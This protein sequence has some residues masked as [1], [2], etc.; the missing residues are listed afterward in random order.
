[1]TTFEEYV[2][3]YGLHFNRKLYEWAVSMMK[4]RSGNKVQV[5]TK[6]DVN[7]FLRNNGV[8]LS[9]DKGHDAAYVHAMLYADCWGSSYQNDRQLALGIKDFLDDPDG[10]DSKAFDH[11]VVDC[12]S[13]GEPIFWDE[14]I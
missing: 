13:K 8:T 12:R 4:D 10:T 3:Q 5:K 14:M 7:T 9:K 6:E 2:D 1:M 11:F